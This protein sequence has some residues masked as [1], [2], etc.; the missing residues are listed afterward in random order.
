MMGLIRRGALCAAVGAAL[1]GAAPSAWAQG[2]GAIRVVSGVTTDRI[3]VPIDRAVVIE[4]DRPVGELSIANPSIAD[5]AVLGENNL[6]ILGR[7]TG[8]TTLT[9]VDDVGLLLA[10]VDV[11][12]APDV[13]EFKE[14]L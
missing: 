14:R 4:T 6:Y 2:S 9:L 1:L 10:K 11:Q 13:T 5:V 7:A 8:R 12:V 3:N